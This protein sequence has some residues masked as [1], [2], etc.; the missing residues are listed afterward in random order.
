MR[1]ESSECD[2][3]PGL[4]SRAKNNNAAAA[5]TTNLDFEV[6]QSRPGVDRLSY[7]S[8]CRRRRR[9]SMMFL[10]GQTEDI[11]SALLSYQSAN[12]GWLFFELC[13]S[14]DGINKDSRVVPR[15]QRRRVESLS[16]AAA[17]ARVWHTSHQR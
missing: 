17:V 9:I 10:R 16:G 12:D 11:L 15:L 1:E 6:E 8:E 14:D 2:P 4:T 13:V 7:L 3:N 5:A